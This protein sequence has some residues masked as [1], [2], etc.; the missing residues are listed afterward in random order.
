MQEYQ[1]VEADSINVS[2]TRT[3]PT[4]INPFE[5]EEDD[6]QK[7][8]ISMRPVALEKNPRKLGNLYLFWYSEPT[9]TSPAMPRIVIGN[10]CQI[11]ASLPICLMALGTLS[12]QLNGMS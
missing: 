2:E 12:F 7:F 6:D 4:S 3:E 1:G 5:T 10:W 8:S 9:L 11:L